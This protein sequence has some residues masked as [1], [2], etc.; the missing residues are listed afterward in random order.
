MGS[1]KR[2]RTEGLGSQRTFVSLTSPEG[3]PAAQTPTLGARQAALGVSL[4][5]PQPQGPA[6]PALQRAGRE[7]GFAWARLG[8][9]VTWR[10]PPSPELAAHG[11]QMEQPAPIAAAYGG[12]LLP[13]VQT[14]ILHSECPPVPALWPQCHYP[15][16]NGTGGTLDPRSSRYEGPC[17]TRACDTEGAC[18]QSGKNLGLMICQQRIRQS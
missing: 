3:A 7:G 14:C 11:A 2:T 9:G 12:C 13:G 17:R 1:G 16:T 15:C 8:L 10:L 18:G 4:L 6:L 5:P